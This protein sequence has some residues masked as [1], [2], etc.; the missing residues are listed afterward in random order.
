MF[1]FTKPKSFPH[2]QIWRSVRVGLGIGVSLLAAFT[3]L[4]SNS[5]PAN[6]TGSSGDQVVVVYNTRVP[7]SKSIAEHYALIRKV[8][9]DQVVG[10]SMTKEEDIKRNDFRD[11]LQKPLAK[12]FA[13]RGLWKIG[14]TIVQ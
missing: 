1:C 7:E 10:L 4:L 3:P 13:D 8:P 6:Q 2:C 12:L 9:K 11:D 5:A 14:S